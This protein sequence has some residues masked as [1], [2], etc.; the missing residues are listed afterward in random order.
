VGTT[1]QPPLARRL[2][3][4]RTGLPV[5]GLPH[6]TAQALPGGRARRTAA[7]R[8]DMNRCQV[9]AAASGLAHKKWSCAVVMIDQM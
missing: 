4:L 7:E 1:L 9:P 3:E 5:D 6:S 2:S 8:G